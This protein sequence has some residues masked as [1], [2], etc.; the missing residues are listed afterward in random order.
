MNCQA[1]PNDPGANGILPTRLRVGVARYDC[2]LYAVLYLHLLCQYCLDEG[3]S[4]L[5]TT[6]GTQ[7]DIQYLARFNGPW[8]WWL[9]STHT[10]AVI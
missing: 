3:K 7:Y 6:L 1:A 9:L 10:Y 8:D 4:G 2:Q 5:S